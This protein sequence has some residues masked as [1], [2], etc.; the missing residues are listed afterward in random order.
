MFN[1]VILSLITCS[2]ADLDVMTVH[3][4]PAQ[5]NVSLRLSRLAIAALHDQHDAKARLPGH[6][7][8]VRSRSFL[9]WNG[10][11]HRCHAGQRTES[12]CCI[13]SRWVSRQRA[14]YLALS[15]YEIRAR[16]LDRLRSDADVDRYTTRTKALEGCGDG[17]PS[18]GCYENNFGAAQRLQSRSRI[19]SGTVD[20]VVSAQL[21]SEFPRV[22]ATGNR[23]HLESHMPGVLHRQMTEAADTEH[24]H[25]ITRLRRR[26][27][28]GV[29][30]RESRA[31]QR[32][33][34]CR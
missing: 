13:A 14:C 30:R 27:S 31:E 32:R 16:N 34:I 17:L 1:T 12:E 6:H 3:A 25:K 8:R 10:L 9:E 5:P 28:Q 33:S 22:A 2:S 15:E 23:H 26:V 21:L 29:E 19:I 11:D 18:G 24:S 7:L 4:P 20:V